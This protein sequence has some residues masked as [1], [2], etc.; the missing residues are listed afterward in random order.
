MKKNYTHFQY[1]SPIPCDA[2]L[3]LWDRG[4][5]NASLQRHSL[6]TVAA[7]PEPTHT[8]KRPPST[9]RTQLLPVRNCGI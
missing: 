4:C 5:R 2:S 7:G 1:S 9:T 8:W 3:P 6:H